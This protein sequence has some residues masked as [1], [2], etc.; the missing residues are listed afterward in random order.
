MGKTFRKNDAMPISYSVYAPHNRGFAKRNKRKR[1]HSLRNKNRKIDEMTFGYCMD[2]P[3]ILKDTRRHASKYS[4]ETK[5]IPKIGWMYDYK[6]EI[7]TQY[8][9]EIEKMRD[10]YFDKFY[11]MVKDE[12]IGIIYSKSPVLI[13]YRNQYYKNINWNELSFIDEINF[14]H[15]FNKIN[16][17]KFDI[18]DTIKNGNLFWKKINW[19]DNK[20]DHKDFVE[21]I[22]NNSVDELQKKHM[23][24]RKKQIERRGKEEIFKGHR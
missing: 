13:N 10:E 19:S 16:W 2:S 22:I 8:F 7:K 15:Q 3:Y 11:K 5:V 1:Q 14:R 20:V 17:C 9:D 23:N 12:Q 6:D 18:F 21:Y 4:N 24:I